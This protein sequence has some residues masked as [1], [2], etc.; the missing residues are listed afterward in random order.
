MKILEEYTLSENDWDQLSRAIQAIQ[1]DK[2]SVTIWTKR[3][4][5]NRWLNL[6]GKIDAVNEINNERKNY[7]I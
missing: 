3:K 5:I 2:A 1:E 7:M 6:T 4:H